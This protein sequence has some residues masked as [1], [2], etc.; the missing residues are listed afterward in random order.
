ML[1]QMADADHE[2]SSASDR[3]EMLTISEAAE[4][5][6][7]DYDT[8]LRWVIKGVLPHVVVGPHNSRRVYRRDVEAL[9][10]PGT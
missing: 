2:S 1:L 10:R 7:V 5:C 8:F 4:L 9:I 6:H 3:R